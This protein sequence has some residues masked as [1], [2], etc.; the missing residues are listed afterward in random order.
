MHLIL[1]CA[2]CV[3]KLWSVIVPVYYHYKP[4]IVL[5]SF[6][7]SVLLETLGTRLPFSVLSGHGTSFFSFEV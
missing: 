7:L 2:M 4:K 5:Y 1:E 6:L 3:E